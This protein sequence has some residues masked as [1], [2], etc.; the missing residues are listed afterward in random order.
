MF[1]FAA[2][3]ADLDARLE[4]LVDQVAANDKGARKRDLAAVDVAARGEG[5]DLELTQALVL[6]RL[7]DT[8]ELG[9]GRAAQD[10]RPEGKGD[11][12][13]RLALSRH[14]GNG[15]RGD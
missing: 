8:I 4:A 3:A 15:R 13:K 11:H 9:L 6:D 12:A 14:G 10:R 1:A 7:G 2:E 5:P